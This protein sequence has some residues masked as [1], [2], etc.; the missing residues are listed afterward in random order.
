MKHFSYVD[1]YYL[2]E[3]ERRAAY[4]TLC[5]KRRKARGAARAKRKA[6]RAARR[7]TRQRA[8]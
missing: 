3:A 6:A 2:P 5:P 1:C 8:K 4:K 7:I